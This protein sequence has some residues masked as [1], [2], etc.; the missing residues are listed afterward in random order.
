MLADHTTAIEKFLD[1]RFDEEEE[2]DEHPDDA[3]FRRA[4]MLLLTQ[5]PMALGQMAGEVLGRTL[6]YGSF[7]GWTPTD[8]ARQWQEAFNAG[9]GAGLTKATERDPI[10]EAKPREALIE[11]LGAAIKE[12]GHVGALVIETIEGVTVA[13]RVAEM[14][15]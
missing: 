7:S 3:A 13:D 8:D 6:D 12:I 4:V 5:V 14:M 1:A 11:G 9:F 2:H 15:P 10:A